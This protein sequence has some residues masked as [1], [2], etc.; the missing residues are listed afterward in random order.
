[1]SHP[2]E[3]GNVQYYKAPLYITIRIHV[4]AH[5]IRFLANA[6]AIWWMLRNRR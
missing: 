4:K 3:S 1:M 2:D 5:F 6:D